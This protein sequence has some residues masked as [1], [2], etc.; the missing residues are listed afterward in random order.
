[1]PGRIKSAEELKELQKTHRKKFSTYFK[2]Y[3]KYYYLKKIKED[4][5]Y[6]KK[7]YQKRK[8][9]T[10]RSCQICPNPIPPT[11]HGLAKVCSNKCLRQKKLTN[12]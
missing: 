9:K 2:N 11:K 12:K 10:I 1:M 8:P 3:Q 4:P 6:N 7:N 5:N